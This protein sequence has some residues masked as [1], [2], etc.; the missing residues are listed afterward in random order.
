MIDR[1]VVEKVAH[2]S[3]LSLTEEEAQLY[4]AQLNDVMETMEVL[5]QIDTDGVEP[6]AHVLPIKNV[7]RADEV[8]E[9]LPK[10]KVLANAPNEVD[11]MFSVPKIV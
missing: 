5:Q 8:G 6:L 2:L 7:L 3:R 11:G 4:A 10:E 1:A 9:S